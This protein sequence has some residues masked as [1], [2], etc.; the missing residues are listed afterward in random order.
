M[1][2]GHKAKTKTEQTVHNV[3][4]W[5]MDNRKEF[6]EQGITE[7]RVAAALG[8]ADIDAKDAVDHLE[9]CEEVVRTPQ[10]STPRQFILKPGRGWPDIRE[11]VL[12]KRTT[13][14]E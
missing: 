9:N 13:G 8:L 2:H 11:R 3:A 7:G 4:Q 12:E 14:K 5:L 10:A 1:A 6:E